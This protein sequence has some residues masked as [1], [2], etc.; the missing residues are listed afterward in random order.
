M[1][2]SLPVS[3]IIVHYGTPDRLRDCLEDLASRPDAPSQVIVVDNGSLEARGHWREQF[4]GIDWVFL[5]AN[6]GFAAGVNA[7]ESLKFLSAPTWIR[8]R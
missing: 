5:E 4:P 2:G 1:S 6:R 8:R 7:G 3:A